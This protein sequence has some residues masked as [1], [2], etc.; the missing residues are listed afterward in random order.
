MWGGHQGELTWMAPRWAMLEKRVSWTVIV[1][2][3]RSGRGVQLGRCLQDRVDY[4]GCMFK[5][6][7]QDPLNVPSSVREITPD[8]NGKGQPPIGADAT[9]IGTDRGNRD[10]WDLSSRSGGSDRVHWRHRR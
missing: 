6:R 9:R 7:D 8:V 5:S 1:G 2:A 10:S 3:R 4:R